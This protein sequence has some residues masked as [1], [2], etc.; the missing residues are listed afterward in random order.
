MKHIL[1]WILMVSTLFGAKVI[2]SKWIEGQTFSAYLETRQISADML[3]NISKDDQKFLSEINQKYNFYELKDKD[4]VL[5]QALIPISEVMQIHLT[6]QRD[7][8]KYDFDIIPIDYDID[9]YF[10]KIIVLNNP[11][12]DT[13]NTIHNQKVAKRLSFALKNV[14]NGKKLHKGDEIDFVYTQSTRVGKPYLMPDIKIARVLIGDKEKFIYVDEDGDGFAQTGKSVAYAVKGKRKVT[15]TKRVPVS[16]KDS[17]FGMPLRHARITSSFSYR[18]YHPILRRY[19]PHHG[20]DFGARKG[21]PLLAVNAGTVSF[22]GWMGGYGN[23]VKIKHAG[24][25]ESLYAHQSRRRVKRGQKVTK[26]QIIG[27]VGS[28]GR[29]TGPHL[30][31]GLMKN[32]RWINPMGVL[33]KKSIKTS[34]LKKFT[35]YEDV[36]TTKYKT[37]AIKGVKE[38]KTKLLHYMQKHTPCYIWSE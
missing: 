11:Y 28:T 14:I 2:E 26:G 16:T 30:H 3:D 31:F 12:I 23:V 34:I 19:R 29:S 17:R 15:Y 8:D 7:S 25:Y 32:G 18:R 35:K 27:Y 36:T 37:V 13:V 21:T 38:N 10:A 24:G 9:E 4:G 22:S 33:R 20:T 1:V 5:L 6:K